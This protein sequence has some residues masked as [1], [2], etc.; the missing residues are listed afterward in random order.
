[1]QIFLM[2]RKRKGV[3]TVGAGAVLKTRSI[4]FSGSF[5]FGKSVFITTSSLN[6]FEA[7][8]RAAC[9][10]S[11]VPTQSNGLS[12]P[13]PSKSRKRGVSE[14]SA[15][16]FFLNMLMISFLPT[17]EASIK[18]AKTHFGHLPHHKETG[19]SLKT[20]KFLLQLANSGKYFLCSAKICAI[21]I[22]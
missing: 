9:D 1:M 8:K 3:G 14:L 6:F 4:S 11:N 16:R 13:S 2:P 10:S 15:K 21:L 7:R 18:K 22:S 19:R 12:F 17:N 5:I 20:L